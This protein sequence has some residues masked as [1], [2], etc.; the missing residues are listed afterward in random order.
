MF[1]CFITSYCNQERSVHFRRR[2]KVI[3]F[4][5]YL[6]LALGWNRDT[7]TGPQHDRY[8]MENQPR[9]AGSSDPGLVS[10]TLVKRPV[11]AQFT[12]DRFPEWMD[13]H[14]TWIV[15]VIAAI[16]LV[17][18]LC[19]GWAAHT[20]QHRLIQSSGHSLVQAATDAA[21]KL[22]MM[23]LERYG[24]IQLLS[25]APMTQG[26]NPEALAQY[27]RELMHAYPAYRWIGVTD[28]RGKIIAATDSSSTTPDQSQRPWFQQA[29]TLTGVRILDAQA[30]DESGGTLAIT[31]IAPLRS[32]EGQFLG[33]IK[34]VVGLPPL[35][36]ILDDT[37][38]VLKDIEWTE[39]SHIEY[40]LL[41]EKGE[42]IADST[43]RQ[44]GNLNLKQLGLPSAALVGMNARGFVEET[45]LRRGTSVVTAYAQMAIAHADPVLRWGILIRIDHDSILAPI[46]SFL[47]NLSLLAILI[48]L[49]LL[50]LVLGM[51]K[52]LHE[53]WRT[54]KRESLRATDAEAALTKRTEALHALVVATRTLSAQRDLDELLSQLLEIARENT[55]ARYAALRLSPDNRYESG[56]FLSSGSDDAAA[57][58][59]QALPLELGANTSL[60]E[61]SA[62]LSLRHLKPHWVSLGHPEDHAPMTSFLG[63]SIRCHGEFFGRLCLANKLTAQ[64]L[65]IDF[66]ELDEQILQALASQAGTA[67]QNLQLLHDS[68]EQARHDP[69]TGLLNHSAILN[70][71][72]Q[73]LSRAERSLRPVAV[74][75]ADLDHFKRVNDTYGHPVG[76]A[77]IREAA[78]RLRESARL[79]DH[80]GRVGGEEFLIV[81]PDCDLDTLQECAER[82][83][84][85]I[86]DMPFDTPSGPLTITV[87]IGATVWSSQNPLTA[88]LLRRMADYALYRVKNRGR[89]GIDIVP[90]PHALLMEQL[91][92][93]G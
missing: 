17:T 35:M 89:N 93:T 92:K 24:D 27:L 37:M 88:E 50:G 62:A 55:G 34:A 74:L 13:R 19:L 44:D 30:S 10:T 53:E 5:P 64:G 12:A 68:E 66:S 22:D 26:Q 32:H 23:I 65:A 69:L 47:W 71:L 63:V 90:H 81:A 18:F 42:L 49:P 82:F 84:T 91:K 16:T 2:R 75:I 57:Q 86:S 14:H 11:Y 9:V 85:A 83:R 78:Q 7:K 59:I 8:R 60:S 54:A 77:V 87:S 45:H 33:A 36:E 6:F 48:L 28:S 46:R 56:E 51:I 29:R 21:S 4:L 43:L 76:D 40:Q 61:E 41:N 58:A 1:A 3:A 52:A 79:Y 73:E 38:H 70:A 31:V 39:E 72:N 15:S 25:A 67:I 80:V 20:V